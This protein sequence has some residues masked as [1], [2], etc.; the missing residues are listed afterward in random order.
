MARVPRKWIIGDGC[1]FHVTWQCHNKSWLLKHRWA[2]SLYYQLLLCYKKKYEIVFYSYAFMDNHIH[3]SGKLKSLEQ[4]SG[5]F[6][7]VNS[8]FAK[9]I[10]QR[11][12]RFGQV[13]RDRF[14]SPCLETEKDLIQEMIYHDLNEVR[15]G[16]VFHP[17]NN[18]FS[19]YAHYA[20]GKP[21]PLLT[22]PEIYLQLGKTQEE[23][24]MAYRG[25]VEEILRTAP[26]KKEGRYTE[27]Y[28][29]RD[30]LWVVKKY[31]DLKR[32]RCEQRW[33]NRQAISN[34]TSRP[35]R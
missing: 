34:P 22:D 19:S 18:E 26:R 9:A 31:E 11:M 3:L 4:L 8:T 25:M 27:A 24:Q 20:Y 10:N 30:P 16:K 17:Q 33:F 5:F 7:V 23:R 12:G 2:K 13:I 28:F 1:L 14:K 15:A 32:F 35:P 21:D 29:I 6:R